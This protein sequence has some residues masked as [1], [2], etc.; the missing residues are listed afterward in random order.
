MGNRLVLLAVTVAMAAGVA[1]CHSAP[2][3]GPTCLGSGEQLVHF[4]AG[5]GQLPAVVIGT[6]SVGLI[7]GHQ[8]GGDLCQWID[9]ARWFASIGYRSMVFDFAGFGWADDG[10]PDPD[11]DVVAAADY[12]KSHGVRSLA[13]IGASMGGGAVVAAA[14][15]LSLPV[16]AVV[17]LSGSQ[18]TFG[19][20]AVGAAARL[21]A[22]L[23]CVAAQDDDGYAD[24][25]RQLCA[26]GAPGQRQLM[27][28]AGK[29]HGVFLYYSDIQVKLAVEAFLSQHAAPGSSTPRPSAGKPQPS[30]DPLFPRRT[31]TRG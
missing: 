31:P 19:V 26:D 4:D 29:A 28:V 9:E 12:L 6:G 21:S 2:Q 16:V 25:A 17:S 30:H 10:A 14:P 27:M 15:R 18:G 11:R 13:L 5:T 23:L 22:P 7:F 24:T 20:D 1:G 8:Y 3:P